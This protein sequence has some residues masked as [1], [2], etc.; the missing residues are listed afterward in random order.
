[1][2]Q[3]YRDGNRISSCSP[4]AQTM[5]ITSAAAAAALCII[6]PAAVLAAHWYANAHHASVQILDLSSRKAEGGR[7]CRESENVI[8]FVLQTVEAEEFWLPFGVGVMRIF[9]GDPRE[10][11]CLIFCPENFFLGVTINLRTIWWT[12]SHHIL[13]LVNLK[14]FNHLL[15]NF[16]GT[17][18]NTLL[19]I[20]Y[21]SIKRFDLL[22]RRDKWPA[23]ETLVISG[24]DFAEFA[25]SVVFSFCVRNKLM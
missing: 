5:D 9:W 10:R 3:C 16:L 22:G 23:V 12:F 25:R 20:C 11:W 14:F 17:F 19:K 4:P 6:V 21:I 2:P 13:M 18:T 8:L 1:M 15:V 24:W 7:T